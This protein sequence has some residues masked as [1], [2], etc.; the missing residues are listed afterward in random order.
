MT[1]RSVVVTGAASAVGAACARRFA[2]A[3][4]RLVLADEDEEKGKALTDALLESGVEATFVHADTNRRLSVHNIIA[5]ALDAY[6]RIDVLAHMVMERFSAPFLETTED[7]FDAVIERNVRGAFLINQAAAKQFVK[8]LDNEPGENGRGVIVNIASV[9][10]VTAAA[11]HV[12][13]A[14]SQGGLHQL[15]KAAAL[16][17]SSHGVRV[18]AVG[19]GAIK[20]EMDKETA[21]KRIREA[22]PL[23]RI[24]DPEE[25]AEVIFFLASDAAS[26]VTGQTVYVD[27][28]RLAQLDS[29]PEEKKSED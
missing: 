1:G 24:G 17:L 12:A 19:V 28:G 18:N 5:E 11:D 10:A 23:K 14:T 22:T 2:E 9:E 4:D 6:D 20:G 21:P 3:G 16:A 15:S 26:Y 29:L 27:G 7:D 13:F 25:V 8:Q